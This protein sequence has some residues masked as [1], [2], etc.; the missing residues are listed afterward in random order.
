MKTCGNGCIDS[1]FLDLGT[2]WRWMVSFTPWPLYPRERAP[3]PLDRRLRG[4]QSRAGLYGQVKILALTGTRNSTPRPS[5]PR[6]GRLGSRDSL[7]SAPPIV[8]QATWQLMIWWFV[9]LLWRSLIAYTDIILEGPRQT[10]KVTNLNSGPPN[11][12]IV[13]LPTG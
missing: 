12:E 13:V 10:T 5:S 11:Y 9:S 8:V 1:R 4:P 2:N 7:H 6:E 3:G